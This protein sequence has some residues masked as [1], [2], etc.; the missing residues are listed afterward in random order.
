MRQAYLIL[1]LIFYSQIFLGQQ[2]Y[3]NNTTAYTN[4][5]YSDTLNKPT[6]NEITI[7]PDFT[8]E[9]WSRPYISCFTWQK[10]E[11]TWKKK[12]NFILFN[13]QYEVSEN[14]MRFTF[15]KNIQQDYFL[16]RFRTDK[17]SALKTK[18]IKIEYV[19][20]FDKHFDGIE[21]ELIL[22]SDNNLQIPFKD[23]PNLDDLASIRIEYSLSNDEKR[24]GYIT[25]SEITN[26]KEKNIPNIVT[27]EFV[28][29]P[30]KETIYRTTTG[31]FVNKQL[32]I[33]SISKTKAKLPDYFNDIT[34]E[35]MYEL[36]K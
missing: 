5:T 10:Q 32:E 17:N 18:S 34:F 20:D 13:D 2:T 33:I 12:K 35:K 3:I 23:I 4:K 27:I 7:N 31:K 16:L 22:D 6:I 30:Q 8:F 26:I 36:L 21:K 19:Y 28:E 29:K 11:G 14:D 24:S 15:D 25:E 9:F 1:I